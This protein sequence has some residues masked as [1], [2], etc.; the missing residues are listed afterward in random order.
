MAN[1]EAGFAFSLRENNIYKKYRN[2][3]KKETFFH[4]MKFTSKVSG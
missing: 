4:T 2:R 1:A 3:K